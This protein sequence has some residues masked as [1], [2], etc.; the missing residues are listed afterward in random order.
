VLNISEFLFSPKTL[1]TV[2]NPI[3]ADMQAEY[4]EALAVRRRS[5]AMWVC[6]RGYWSLMK[7]IGLYSLLRTVAEVWRKV[8]M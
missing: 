8:S 5:K 6:V 1:R 4:F 3:V 7:A 2:V